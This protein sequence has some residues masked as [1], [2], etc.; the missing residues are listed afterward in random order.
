MGFQSFLFQSC[1]VITMTRGNQR[2]I[3]RLKAQKRAAKHNKGPKRKQADINK[4]KE[5]D[6][7]IMRRKQLANDEKKKQGIN[8]KDNKKKKKKNNNLDK[9]KKKKKNGY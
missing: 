8:G 9:N 2:N 3:D 1:L 7:E 5:T 6:A 4:K